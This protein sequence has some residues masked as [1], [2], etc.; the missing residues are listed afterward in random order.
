MLTS[1]R[2]QENE[3]KTVSAITINLSSPEMILA[4]SYGEVTKPETINYRSY[5][6]EKDGLFSEKIFGPTKDWECHCG[7]YRGIRYK[8]II[9]DRCGVEV[10]RKDVRRKRMGH[11]KLAVPVVHIWFFKSMPSKIGYLLGI[12][13]RELERVIYY[14]K[15]VVIQPG[16]TGLKR[17]DLLLEKEYLELM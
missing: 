10:T 16:N 17:V 9:C 13:V 2:T 1:S 12:P 14:E 5:K 15:Y 8:G 3:Q 6:P 7:K 4:R 11:I